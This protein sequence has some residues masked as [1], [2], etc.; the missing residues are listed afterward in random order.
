LG[1]VFLVRVIGHALA[2]PCARVESGIPEFAGSAAVPSSV[3][4]NAGAKIA[5]LPI[6]GKESLILRF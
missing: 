6:H 2:F 3:A 4:I 5:D 1:R